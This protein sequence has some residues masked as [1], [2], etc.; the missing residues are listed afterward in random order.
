MNAV[1]KPP[2]FTPEDLL[3][4]PDGDKYELVDGNLVECKM[5]A[6]SCY[7]AGIIFALLYPHCKTNRLGRLFPAD[8][9]Y[10]CFPG[11]PGKVRKP[12]VSFI[13]LGR[14]VGERIPKGHIQVPPDLAVEV[15]SPNDLASEVNE[16]V[17][18]Y[19]SARVS[20]VWVVDPGPRTVMVYHADG[21]ARCLQENDE[22]TGETI[23]PSFHCR[24]G[25]LFDDW[26]E[27]EKP[28]P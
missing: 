10:Q 11:E 21:S 14:L 5:G 4:M 13:R 9:S 2:K 23:I 18:E 1:V 26:G 20:L 28:E 17:K 7:I 16:K 12:D 27:A 19:L 24:V 22:L 6:E 8:A 15:I 25:D 3:R